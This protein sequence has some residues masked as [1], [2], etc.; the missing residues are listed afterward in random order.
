MRRG[1]TPRVIKM[2]A[3]GIVVV[4]LTALTA[5]G[6]SADASTVAHGA[7]G[8][9]VVSPAHLHSARLDVR[10]PTLKCA[11][12]PDRSVRLGIFGHTRSQ[13]HTSPWLAAIIASCRSGRAHYVAGFGQR[14]VSNPDRVRPGDLYRVIVKG[15]TS[16]SY[17]FD[18]LTTGGASGGGSGGGGPGSSGPVILPQVV[19]GARRSGAALRLDPAVTHCAVNGSAIGSLHHYRQQQVVGNNIVVSPSA[20]TN[21]GT[22]FGLTVR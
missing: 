19:L 9:Y 16:L 8:G 5:L 1:Y 12:S 11:T 17:E 20:L 3:A 15:G 10:V 6:G 4:A 14:N 18:D 2:R 22:A 7:Q 13:G 21:R